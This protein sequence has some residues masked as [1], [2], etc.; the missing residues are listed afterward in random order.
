[1]TGTR[2]QDP[3]ST[4]PPA[5]AA[6]DG[7]PGATRAPPPCAAPEA[8]EDS[9]GDNP[10]SMKGRTIGP[11]RISAQIGVGG[12]GAV[13][14]ADQTAPVRREVALK[15]I[16]AGFDSEE[17]LSRFRAERELLARMSHPYIAQVLDWARP[18]RAARTSPWSTCRAFPSPPSATGRG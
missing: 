16:K 14:L 18:A 6:A 9:A 1:M 12:M 11:Y 8:L 5:P 10:F 2:D 4:T 7:D 17:L 15:V 13:Y 3:A